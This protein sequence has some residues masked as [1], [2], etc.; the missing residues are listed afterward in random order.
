MALP[1]IDVPTFDLN[2][3]SIGKKVKFRPFLVKEEKLLVMANESSDSKDVLQT[4]QQ[5]IT[6]CS[7]GK[8][9]GAKLPLYEVQKVFLDIRS[10]S[11]G[12]YIELKAA[13]VE[14]DAANDVVL[15][16]DEIEIVKSEKHTPTIK[17]SDKMVI[18]MRYP[19]VNEIA[20][21]VSAEAEDDIY[22]VVANN[23][24]TLYYGDEVIDFQGNPPDERMEWVE[25]LSQEQFGKVKEFFETM[26]QLYHT[27]DFVCKECK[28]DNYLIIDGYENFFV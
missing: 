23:I 5:I 13:C 17:V 7:F 19:S 15:D 18:E 20:D 6:N 12:Q 26:P 3:D 8:V 9:D 16:L 10:Q 21:L 24:E 14:C 25:N 28:K 4:A 11:I 27:I 2:I 1:K 22:H